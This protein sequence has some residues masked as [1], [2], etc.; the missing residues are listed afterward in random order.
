MVVCLQ[1]GADSLHN[2][3]PADVTATP[4]PYHFLSRLNPIWFYLSRIGL[5]RLSWKKAIKRVLIKQ[6]KYHKHKSVIS[7]PVV[8]MH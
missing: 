3:G 5:P 4:K 1:R 6:T 8:P 2:Y 7:R